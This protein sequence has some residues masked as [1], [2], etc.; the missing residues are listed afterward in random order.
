MLRD[1][2]FN[3]GLPLICHF[4]F[5]FISKPPR[6]QTMPMTD[7]INTFVAEHT[8]FFIRGEVF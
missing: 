3:T 7:K 2:C 5:F 6:G 1:I 8:I 4:Y